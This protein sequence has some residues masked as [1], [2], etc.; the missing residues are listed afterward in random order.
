MRSKTQV[1]RAPN[2]STLF[3]SS[4]FSFATCSCSSSFLVA[5]SV[6][7]GRQHQFLQLCP[8]TPI[9]S[10]LDTGK[11]LTCFEISFE[12]PSQ[13]RHPQHSH[14]FRFL[15]QQSMPQLHWFRLCITL[16][17]SGLRADGKRKE[18]GILQ[19]MSLEFKF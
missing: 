13:L 8:S 18:N 10:P 2:T 19:D 5:S 17:T 7:A 14:D 16:F 6:P 9:E 3:S 12:C 4:F 1:L 15:S 11:A